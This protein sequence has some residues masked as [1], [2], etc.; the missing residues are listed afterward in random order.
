[1]ARVERT[2]G[3]LDRL[4]RERRYEGVLWTLSKFDRVWESGFGDNPPPPLMGRF[5]IKTCFSGRK[6]DWS[7]GLDYWI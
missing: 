1:M 5:A 4:V 3:R 2:E 6:K 7:F